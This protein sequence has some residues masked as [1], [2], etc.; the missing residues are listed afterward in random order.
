[1]IPAWVSKYIGIPYLNRGRSYQGADCFGLIQLIYRS[2]FGIAITEQSYTDSE[3]RVATGDA[4]KI[5]KCDWKE[6][7]KPKFGDIVLFTIK[8]QAVHMGM[9]LD[10]TRFIHSLKDHN[11]AVGRLD[12][13]MWRTRIEGTY[14]WA[15]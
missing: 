11:S 3:D 7:H 1:M 14:E 12:N 9:I 13:P 2:Q 6:T 15:N 10:D 8:G 4:L 5:G